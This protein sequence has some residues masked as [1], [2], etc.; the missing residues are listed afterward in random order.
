MSHED[1]WSERPGDLTRCTLYK[2]RDYMY[3]V[4]VSADQ[5][6]HRILRILR[7]PPILA[8]DKTSV[9]DEPP[10]SPPEETAAETP[11][12]SPPGTPTHYERSSS[13]VVLSLSLIHI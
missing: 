9:A 8:Q 6:R 10:K 1:V 2:S 4:Y 12:A 3:L 7:V 5:T 13:S 11:A